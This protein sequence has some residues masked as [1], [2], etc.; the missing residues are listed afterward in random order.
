MM[1]TKFRMITAGFSAFAVLGV[2]ALAQNV[3]PQASPYA[4]VLQRIHTTDVEITYHRPGVKERTIW[5]EL[6]PFGKVWRAGANNNTTFE[7]STDVMIE[8]EKLPAGKYGLHIIPEKDSWVIAFNSVNNSWGSFRYDA[9]NDVLRVTVKPVEAPHQ[10]W[11]QYGFE[12][13]QG[14][15]AVCYLHWEKLKAPFKIEVETGE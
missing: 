12:D 13:T 7:C 10:E 4:E 1:T 9:G 15:S 14:S 6:V 2:A 8:G 3:Q 11:L 5:G